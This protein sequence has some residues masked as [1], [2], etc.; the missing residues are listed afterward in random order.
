MIQWRA[1]CDLCTLWQRFGRAAR[2]FGIEAIA[3]FLVEPMYFDETR[4]EK[5]ARKLTRD[6][7]SRKKQNEHE[8]RTITNLG[9]RKRNASVGQDLSPREA[10]I[11][12][13]PQA[14]STAILHMR[15]IS[16]TFATSSLTAVP[17]QTP[18]LETPDGDA[19]EDAV[20]EDDGPSTMANR[21]GES[22]N[23]NVE[24]DRQAIYA[25]L[26]SPVEEKKGQKRKKKDGTELE[27]AMDDMINAGSESV[28]R[29]FKCF[30]APPALLFGNTD[31][32]KLFHALRS[33]LLTL[34]LIR[35]F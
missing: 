29:T 5:A 16:T 33:Y 24:K 4:E 17:I 34:M 7:K 32:G 10:P 23:E 25:G 14:P 6:L 8:R 18:P 27:P 1:T 3:L 22:A 20:S 30:R 15:F 2:D 21:A 9:K 31:F 13:A 19:G 28:G 26:G 11:M 12:P 35:S